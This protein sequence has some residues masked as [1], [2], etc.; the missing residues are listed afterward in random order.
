METSMI[1]FKT[2]LGE[3]MV[4]LTPAEWKKPNSRTGESR[5]DI[6]KQAMQDGQSVTTVDNLE[7]VV[8]DNAA[9]AKAIQGFLA[10]GNKPFELE[11]KG[12][13]TISS[14]LIGKSPMFGG[15]GGAGGGTEATAV[16]ESAQC[17]W[18]AAMLKEGVDKPIEHFTPTVL[19]Q[20]A[21]KIEVGGTTLDEIF[22]IDP[23]WAYSS[24]ATAQL[25]IK[26]KFV[27][28]NHVFHRD[29]K[30][31]KMIYAAKKVAFKNSD[32][33]P[34]KD[35]KWNPGDIW[36]VD[37][38]VDLKKELDTSSIAALNESLLRLYK[39]RKVVGISLKLVKKKAKFDELNYDPSK[40]DSH[41]LKSVQIKSGRGTFFSNK[42]GMIEFDAGIMEIRPN[43]YLGSNKV[44][45][46]GKTARG[47]G[48][49][50]G[51]IVPY[52]KRYMGHKLPDHPTLKKQ[53][54]AIDK[55]NATEIKKF[56]DMAKFVDSSIG[57]LGD[58]KVDLDSKDAG[59]ISAKLAVVLLTYAA[60]KNKGKKA[61]DFI[62]G[63]V[64]YAGSKSEDASVYVKVYE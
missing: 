51:V 35:D 3:A 58:F 59:W 47:G 64:N 50:W 16:A 63:I 10:N 61:N 32:L 9:N 41:T 2:F 22:G 40:L 39:D 1:S 34:M 19:K 20:Y 56:Y 48:A 7:V 26:N 21:S 31:M 13:K 8:L 42:G 4:K 12:N 28:R 38:S 15:G 6:L 24:Y 60:K 49:G 37:P 44:E 57:T 23:N 11:I 52:A 54:M 30:V 27:N 25:L 33:P 5:I 18:T 17:L 29:S 36:A 45:I 46:K 43:N 55:G 62:T 53:A 14:S